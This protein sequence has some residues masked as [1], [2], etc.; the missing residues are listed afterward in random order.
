MMYQTA[1]KS[2]PLDS[3]ITSK[4]HNSSVYQ[5]KN[6]NKALLYVHLNLF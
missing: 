2:W 5:Y 4:L 1:A 6:W 3:R